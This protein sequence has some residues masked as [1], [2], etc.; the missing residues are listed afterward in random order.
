MKVLVLNGPNLGRLGRRQ[1]EIYGTTTH[2]ELAELCI[3]WGAPLGLRV[4]VRQTNHEG[5]LIDWVHEAA[6]VKGIVI[7]PELARLLRSFAPL[8]VVTHFNHPKEVTPDAVDQHMFRGLDMGIEGMWAGGVGG[9]FGAKLAAAGHEVGFIARGDHLAGLRERGL[10]V[11]SAN[12]DV[13]LAHPVVTDDP[14]T[15]APCDI[16]LFAVKLWDTEAAAARVQPL[17]ARGGVIIPF[18][19]G[20]ESI[21][22]VGPIVGA[23]RA[24]GGPER[25]CRRDTVDR[26]AHGVTKR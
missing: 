1:P 16:V 18:Q 2:A 17:V 24:R 3:G 21:A 14:A 4:E 20:V 7:N 26:D 6:A 9:N 15:L 13:R 25:V 23:E 11:K 8:F 22:R 5:K 12:G 19:N 10:A